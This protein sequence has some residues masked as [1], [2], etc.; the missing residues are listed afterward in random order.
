[1]CYRNYKSSAVLLVLSIRKENIEQQ[2]MWF[3]SKIINYLLAAINNLNLIVILKGLKW[4]YN[5]KIC[6][7]DYKKKKINLIDSEFCIW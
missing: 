7:S 1:M 2:G 6:L 3:E 4:Q 5:C